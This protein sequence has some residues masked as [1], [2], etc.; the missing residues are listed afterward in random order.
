MILSPPPVNKIR[1]LPPHRTRPVYKARW[2]DGPFAFLAGLTSLLIGILFG[3]ASLAFFCVGFIAFM[4]GMLIGELCESFELFA[5]QLPWFTTTNRWY[6]LLRRYCRLRTVI[7]ATKYRVGQS[8]EDSCGCIS[9]IT[10]ITAYR[11][12]IYYRL[13]GFDYDYRESELKPLPY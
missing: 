1:V 6:V 7:I 9:R 13:F 3:N 12:K 4:C 8:V 11:G 10:E 5:K 2:M